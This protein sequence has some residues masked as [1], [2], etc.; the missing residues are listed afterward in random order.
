MEKLQTI[1]DRVLAGVGEMVAERKARP[2]TGE[3]C[4]LA[5][6]LHCAGKGAGGPADRFKSQ[7]ETFTADGP[8]PAQRNQVPKTAAGNKRTEVQAAELFGGVHDSHP[9]DTAAKVAERMSA[10]VAAA[11]QKRSSASGSK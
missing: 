10:S 5:H 11:G 1:L 2:F 9:A 8:L 6:D 4:A 3:S 7:R